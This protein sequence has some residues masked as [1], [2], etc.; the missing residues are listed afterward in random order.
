MKGGIFPMAPRATAETAIH[1][2]LSILDAFLDVGRP[3]TVEE[4]SANL[5]LAP[6]TAYRLLRALEEKG[7]VNSIGATKRY[8]VGTKVVRLSQLLRSASPTRDIGLVARPAMERLWSKVAETVNLQVQAGSWRYCCA[9]LP[10]PHALR[11]VAGVGSLAPIENG[12]GGHVLLAHLTAEAC[13]EILV[14][15]ERR[16]AKALAKARSF[17]SYLKEVR[18]RGFATSYGSA[19][20][21][22]RGI[23]VPIFDAQKKCI[24]AL[25]VGGPGHRFTELK[26]KQALP[27]LRSAATEISEAIENQ[28]FAHVVVEPAVEFDKPRLPLQEAM[29]KGAKAKYRIVRDRSRK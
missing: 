5:M 7:I 20:P 19:V 28:A 22:G 12:A 23:A 10:S 6:S 29:G 25:N 3:M 18:E 8:F 24:A 1:K 14:Q 27:F 11:L 16:S 4:I 2:A 13:A 9:E 17:R 26:A 21:D 15:G